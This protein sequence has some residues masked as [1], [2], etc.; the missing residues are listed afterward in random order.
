[1]H[2]I[3]LDPALPLLK[4]RLRT[5]TSNPGIGAKLAF[6]IGCAVPDVLQPNET[7]GGISRGS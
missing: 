4:I 7:G 6:T 5:L 1:M 2:R 3:R